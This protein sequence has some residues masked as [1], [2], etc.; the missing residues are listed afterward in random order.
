[1]VDP[2][3]VQNS[4][5]EIMYVNAVLGDAVGVV[6]RLSVSQSAFYAAPGEPSG[7]IP[8]VM[9]APK[10]RAVEFSLTIIGPTEFT[11]PNHEGVLEQSTLFQVRHQSIR[12]LVGFLALPLDSAGQTPVLVPT[13]VVELDEAYPLFGEPAS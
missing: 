12:G 13:R 5:M 6:V 1:M 10:V 8:G 9:I 2:Q 4:G 7:E 3:Q 11:S